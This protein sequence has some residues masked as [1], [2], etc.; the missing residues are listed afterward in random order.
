VYHNSEIFILE[1]FVYVKRGL[2]MRFA[3]ISLMFIG[4]LVFLL[5]SVSVQAE[6]S[7]WVPSSDIEVGSGNCNIDTDC[8][9]GQEC[10]NFLCES[11]SPGAGS[12]KTFVSGGGCGTTNDPR[13]NSCGGGNVCTG[14]GSCVQCY[15]NSQ[16]S[17]GQFCS[18]SNCASCATTPV[19]PCQVWTNPSYGCGITDVAIGTICDTDG[20]PVT[21]AFC[22]GAGT[23]STCI[24][25]TP[26]GG[27]VPVCCTPGECADNDGVCIASGSPSVA[28]GFFNDYVCKK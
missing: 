4:L 26:L 10:L 16:C 22:D 5:F 23:C 6:S 17:P 18:G 13:G 20:N 24:D 12:C 3:G 11:C 8:L 28:A 19:S 2:N 25:I 1:C 27:G 15:Q 21:E 9:T 7:G 14:G